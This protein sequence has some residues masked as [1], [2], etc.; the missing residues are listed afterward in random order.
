MSISLHVFFFKYSIN[1]F[2]HFGY[3][4]TY[5][6][7]MNTVEYSPPVYFYP[8]QVTRWKKT[9]C[10]RWRRTF[11][12]WLHME[13]NFD[14]LW[15]SKSQPHPMSKMPEVT[16]ILHCPHIASAGDDHLH[17]FADVWPYPY[18]AL[19]IKRALTAVVGL[20]WNKK[21]FLVAF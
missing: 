21:R 8:V 12:S 16:H 13:L 15:P 10:F 9:I 2:G 7:E 3:G 14:E 4:L 19:K 18:S 5:V 17:A 6:G 1:C 11:T 20:R